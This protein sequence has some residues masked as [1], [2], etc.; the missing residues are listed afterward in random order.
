MT[1]YEYLHLHCDTM[2]CS[3]FIQWGVGSEGNRWKMKAWAKSQ[4]W[5]FRRKDGE[6]DAYCEDCSEVR[7][8]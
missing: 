4:G 8:A 1:I 7:D 5:T 6:E 3:S 2:G